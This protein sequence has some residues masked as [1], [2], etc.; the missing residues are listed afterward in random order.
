MYPCQRC[1][2][3]K[4][5]FEL[6]D[7]ATVR[8]TC[9]FCGYEVEFPR[10]KSAAGKKTKTDKVKITAEG[11]PC[12]HCRA[13]VRKKERIGTPKDVNPGGYYFAWW[14]VCPNPRCRALYMVEDAK[15][16]FPSEGTNA[17]NSDPSELLV[18]GLGPG[19][20]PAEVPWYKSR[21]EMLE[22]EVQI[23]VR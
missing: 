23:Q 14:F 15:R 3:N 17:I 5:K 12:H 4:W 8:A 16:W 6:P 7:S 13:P 21:E 1:L 9:E 19:D 20:D 11:Q 2:E 10:K 18:N 22:A